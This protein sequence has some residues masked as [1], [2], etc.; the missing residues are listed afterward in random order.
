MERLAGVILQ[1]NPAYNGGVR[2]QR[3]IFVGSFRNP[4]STNSLICVM[5]I[6]MRYNALHASEKFSL[7]HTPAPKITKAYLLGALHD[8]TETKYTFRISQK[9][10]EYIQILSQGIIDLGYKAWIYKEGKSRNLYIVEFS[11]KLLSEV[12]IRSLND[13]KDYIRGYFD[14]EGSVPR[15]LQARYYIY[16]AQ[17]NFEDL[18]QLRNY[19]LELGINCGEI[20][21]PSVRVDPNYFRFFVLRESFE[22][23]GLKI[24]SYHPEKSKYLRMKI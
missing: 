8:S 19:L 10:Y 1:T 12:V 16:F 14:S 2:I 18:K 21:T 11:K 17:K 15:S 23:F 5:Q 4:L 13:K 3:I 6:E 22:K 20:H 24:G 7:Y 9:Y